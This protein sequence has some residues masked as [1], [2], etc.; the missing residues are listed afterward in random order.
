MSDKKVT[1]EQNDTF[2]TPPDLFRVL[3]EIFH[4]HFDLAASDANTKV[5]PIGETRRHFT[6]ADNS[7]EQD[8]RDA[9]IRTNRLNGSQNP[10]CFLNPPFSRK[11]QKDAFIAKASRMAAAGVTTVCILP[12]KTDTASWHE[13]IWRKP[14]VQIEY[15]RGRPRFYLGFIPSGNSGWSP[16]AVVIFWN[17]RPTIL[18]EA[19]N[20]EMSKQV[21][22]VLSGWK[23]SLPKKPRV[24]KEKAVVAP[25]SEAV[26]IGLDNK[27]EGIAETKVNH[28]ADT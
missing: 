21:S 18:E 3:N 15:L 2:E 4:F 5:A 27:A 6:E 28:Q 24:K 12:V 11:G 10:Y 8:W 7:L 26:A 22:K 13:Y 9:A 19:H 25:A 17:R 20:M 1:I 16:I 14:A 23:Q